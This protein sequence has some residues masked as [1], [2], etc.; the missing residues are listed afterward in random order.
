M[1]ANQPLS[2]FTAIVL[3]ADRAPGDAVAVA[4]GVPGK[5]LAPV[6]GAPMVLRVMDALA[7][8][9]E[10][11]NCVLCG[12]PRP[13]V[14]GHPDLLACLDRPGVRWMANQAT[15]STS[16]LTVLK[17]LP[18]EAPVLV[19]TADHALLS[20]EMV[21]FFCRSARKSGC[22]LA[23][24][25]AT[26]ETI[27]AEY[28]G[29]RRTLTRLRDGAYCGCNLFA[30]LTPRAREA[31]DFWRRVESQR[32]K[33]LRVV[34]VLGLMVVLRYLLGVLTLDEALARL[35]RR[36]KM[37]VTAVKMPFANAAVDVDTP[38]DW[39]LV[40]DIATGNYAP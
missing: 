8:S 39:K 12:P 33:P 35:S 20:P 3:A 32:K 24:A 28:P 7:A 38:D 16:A 1:S 31:A 17:S 10:I 37:D 36:L 34:G 40:D 14:D 4:A 23:A 9:V 15:P 11:G 21:D 13:I 5:C 6:A 29:M 27:L 2:R 19:T 22:D 18:P 25:L 30:F 26:R